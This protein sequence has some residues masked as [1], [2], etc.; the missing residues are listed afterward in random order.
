MAARRCYS[1]PKMKIVVT[2]AT[3]FIGSALVSALH[4]RGDEV[5]ALVRD[6]GSAQKKL[7]N[8]AR[9]VTADLE[10]AGPWQAELDG[11]DA[12]IHLA[13][14]P[15][16][17]HRWDAR[18]KQRIRDSR[19]ESTHL[20]ANTIVMQSNARRVR[21]LITASGIDYYAFADHTRA[22][23]DDE[24][25]ERDPPGSSF[26]ASVCRNWERETDVARAA[27]VRT[28]QMRTAVVLGK[29]GGA[30]PLLAKQFKFFLGG[31]L[32]SG[33]QWWSWIHLDDVVGAY[34]AAITDVRFVGP[35]NLV[36]RETC[37][38]RD[39]ASALGH[40]LH[41][42]SFLP[43]PAFALRAAVGEFSDYLLNGRRAIPAA[44]QALR[45][46]FAYPTLQTALQHV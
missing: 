45:F 13:G 46:A 22:F 21:T 44:L 7:S 39:F 15:L 24:I 33:R 37:R 10:N 26:L 8:V 1:P 30:L 23:D 25:I 5:V 42:P 20:I 36:A 4:A 9:A 2:G 28:V 43:T 19:V 41:R 3:G 35:Y 31:R 32:G 27:A 29:D 38:Q 12:V 14:E 6:A 11:A 18:A 16:A 34:L 40:A 17:G